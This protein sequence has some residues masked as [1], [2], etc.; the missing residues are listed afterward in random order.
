MKSY[1][2]AAWKLKAGAFLL[3]ILFAPPVAGQAQTSTSSSR[4]SIELM[5]GQGRLLQ[6]DEAAESVYVGDTTIADLR[7]VAPDVVYVY[8][9]KIGS[10]NLIAISAEHKVRANVAFRVVADPGAANSAVRDLQPTTHTKL[11]LFGNRVAATGRA[12]S[13]EEA[14]DVQNTA[15]TYSPPD[16]PPINNTTISSSQQINIRVRFAEVSRDDVQR[17]GIGSSGGIAFGGSGSEVDALVGAMQRNGMLTILAEPNLTASSGRPA[18]FLAGGEIPI[19]TP[20]NQAG[21]ITVQYKPFGVSLEFTPTLIRTNRIALRVK[22]EVSS[23]SRVGA[24]KANGVDLPS[25]MV[26]RADT[27][28]EVASGQTFAIAGLFQRQMSLDFDR[29]PE[30]ADLPILGTL[31]RSARYRRD[32]TELVILI[33]P[34]LVKPVRDRGLA[35]PLDRPAPLPPPGPALVKARPLP[36]PNS[37]FVFK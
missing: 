4:Q 12:G 13:V 10:T 32:E 36:G 17:L 14:V 28:V 31:F 27:T 34:L 9:R 16:Q 37:G 20:G 33:T 19:P 8:G 18:S 15:D 35:T 5:V 7:V 22:P 3:A 2:R 26:R 1:V 25:L 11:R 24:V 21:Q 6:L 23:L 30:I 29:T